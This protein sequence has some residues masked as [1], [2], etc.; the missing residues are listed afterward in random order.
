MTPADTPRILT[1]VFVDRITWFMSS[2]GR[3]VGHGVVKTYDELRGV[4][5][6]AGAL[7]VIL[8]RAGG[9]FHLPVNLTY[10]GEW[11]VANDLER[12]EL[13]NFFALAAR[14]FSHPA[15]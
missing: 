8:Y 4:Q 10:G 13:E 2:A 3:L 5:V 15:P 6:R 11:H 7:E 12:E 9:G 14:S 1:Q